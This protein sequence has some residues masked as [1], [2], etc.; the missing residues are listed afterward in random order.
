MDEDD[1]I[2]G[3]YDEYDYNFNSD[4]VIVDN[5]LTDDELSEL[6]EQENKR[7]FEQSKTA[8]VN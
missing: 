6:K 3:S 5:M 1:R 4:A 8:S 7:K 2:W